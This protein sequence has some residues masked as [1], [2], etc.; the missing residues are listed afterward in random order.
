MATPVAPLKI[1]IVYIS[2]CRLLEPY[3]LRKR[4]L[5]IL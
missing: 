2:I 1:S 3:Y 5:N 4:F